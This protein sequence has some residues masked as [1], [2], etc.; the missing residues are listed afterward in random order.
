MTENEVDPQWKVTDLRMKVYG[1]SISGGLTFAGSLFGVVQALQ[2]FDNEKGISLSNILLIMG[3][4]MFALVLATFFSQYIRLI[5]RD[6]HYLIEKERR[7]GL[8]V[9]GGGKLDKISETLIFLFLVSEGLVI[10]S[11]IS[12]LTYGYP[13]LILLWVILYLFA[14]QQICFNTMKLL[15]LYPKE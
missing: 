6:L 2:L 9:G 14:S 5:E 12:F 4:S 3:I 8:D 1:A 10:F 11:K 13:Y 7:K 15:Q